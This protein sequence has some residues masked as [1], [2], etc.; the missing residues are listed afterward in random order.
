MSWPA[1]ATSYSGT[2]R[3]SPADD[4]GNVQLELSYHHNDASG[5]HEIVESNDVPAPHVVNN[6][7]TIVEDAG[8]FTA[9]GVFSGDQGAGTWTFAPSSQFVRDLQRRG[10]NAPTDEQQLELAMVHFKMSSLDALLAAGFARPSA[11]DLVRLAEH[12]VSSDYIA[13]M[14]GLQFSPKTIDALVRLRDHGVTPEYMHGL[15]DLGFHP[16]A[17]ELVR[18]RDHGVTVAF[19]ERLR[20]H[21][22]T[23]LSADELI[24]LRDHGF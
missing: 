1:L 11:G 8:T 6:Q 17:D 23:H 9:Q 20:S 13:A 5:N 4:A 3:I 22:Y 21:G 7:F 24:R 15:Q 2:W 10:V 16:S 19:V 14:K 12:G 18:L